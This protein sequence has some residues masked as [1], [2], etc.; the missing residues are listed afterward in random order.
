MVSGVASVGPRTASIPS[1]GSG[2]IPPYDTSDATLTRVEATRSYLPILASQASPEKK[3]A[4][5]L[6]ARCEYVNVILLKLKQ[7][8]I[9][10]YADLGQCFSDKG[11]IG[12]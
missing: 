2:E 4:A 1:Q 9:I 3:S 8:G 6:Q 11:S 7:A 12:S 10:H 5:L